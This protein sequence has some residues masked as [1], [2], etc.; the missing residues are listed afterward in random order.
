MSSYFDFVDCNCTS[1]T[2]Y[3][4]FFAMH[5]LLLCTYSQ[6]NFIK[7]AI[8]QVLV[9]GTFLQSSHFQLSL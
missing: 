5:E 1:C 4:S 7:V 9:S 6:K 3:M 8:L 2:K